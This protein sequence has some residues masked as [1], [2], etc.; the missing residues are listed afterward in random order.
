MVFALRDHD[1][2]APGFKCRQNILENEIV[3]CLIR[4]KLGV[5]LLNGNLLPRHAACRPELGLPE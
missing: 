5:K 3:P 2:G 4:S 1:R